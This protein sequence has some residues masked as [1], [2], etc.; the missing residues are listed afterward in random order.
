MAS[1]VEAKSDGRRAEDSASSVRRRRKRAAVRIGNS[2]SAPH[3]PVQ[4][5]DMVYGDRLLGCIA[6][7]ASEAL[8]LINSHLPLHSPADMSLGTAL[9]VQ[10]VRDAIGDDEALTFLAE[11]ADALRHW[12]T[13]RVN[14]TVARL[15]RK[16]PAAPS[17]PG[18]SV[19]IAPVAKR[20]GN[21]SSGDSD[22]HSSGMND[23]TATLQSMGAKS[24][25]I[26]AAVQELPSR[27]IRLL[28]KDFC[29]ANLPAAMVR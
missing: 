10:A 7:G 12:T 20:L 21:T 24:S 4:K 26:E 14:R 3:S 11:G 18:S 1:S 16:L 28:H 2:P 17:A 5:G 8:D 27:F 6:V 9:R 23:E 13:T 25:A 22:I 29:M 19:G 15:K